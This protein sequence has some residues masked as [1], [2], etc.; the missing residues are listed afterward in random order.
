MVRNH[1]A[2][3][4]GARLS[5]LRKMAVS[6]LSLALVVLLVACGG[7]PPAPTASVPGEGTAMRAATQTS[8]SGA[9]TVKATWAGRDAG[10]VFTVAMD[11][12]SVDLNDFDLRQLALLRANDEPV[13]PIAW[14][15]PKSGHHREGA[16][17]F[18]SVTVDGK[19]VLGPDVRSVELVIRDVAGIPERVFR[20]DP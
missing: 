18:P 7:S 9:V 1:L 12:H 5:S 2:L 13:Q 8:E 17:T 16:L 20:W 19:P 6:G 15:A 10:P 3:S 14:D 11:T 4:W